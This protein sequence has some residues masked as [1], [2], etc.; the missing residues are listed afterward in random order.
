MIRRPPPSRRRAARR[1]SRLQRWLRHAAGVPGNPFRA[2]PTVVAPTTTPPP[3]SPTAV[4][5]ATPLA[6][7]AFWVKNFKPTEMW[8]G[9]AGQPGVISFG[10]TSN[11]FCSFQVVRPQDGSRLYVLNPYSKDYFWIDADAVGP[12]PRPHR[13]GQVRSR[14]TRTATSASSTDRPFARER[15]VEG[16]RLRVT[17]WNVNAQVDRMLAPSPHPTSRRPH[18]AGHRRHGGR[19]RLAV[20]RPL[21]LSLDFALFVG[22]AFGL[23]GPPA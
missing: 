4:P 3:P 16:D 9:P 19:V 13:V 10:T 6:F 21:A 1:H 5:T 12:V 11:Q 15:A 17:R 2:T 18:F 22:L 23:V 20:R 14:R 8:S 7:Q